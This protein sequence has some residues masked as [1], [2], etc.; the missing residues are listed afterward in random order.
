MLSLHIFMVFNTFSQCLYRKMLFVP[1]MQAIVVSITVRQ[2]AQIR[3]SGHVV[4]A[5]AENVAKAMAVNIVK[6]LL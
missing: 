4:K 6:A 5:L 2:G 1:Q 3:V